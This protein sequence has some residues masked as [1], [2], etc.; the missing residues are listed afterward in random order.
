MHELGITR[1]VI[2]ICSERAR[3]AAVRRVTLQI[4]TLAGVQAEAVRFCFDICAKGTPLEGAVLEII[5]VPGSAVCG[6][7][8]ATVTL[9]A[10]YGRCDCG[11]A[12]LRLVAGEELNVKEMEVA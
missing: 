12:N 9:L 6:D 8:G 4:G 5:A 11:G 2:A 1:N 10:L 3:G 7:C